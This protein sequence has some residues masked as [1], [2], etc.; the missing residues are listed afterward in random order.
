MI[1]DAS[2]RICMAIR[3]TPGPA[4]ELADP[5]RV[6]EER[7]AGLR[8]EPHFERPLPPFFAPVGTRDPLLDDTRRLEKALAALNV[9]VRG[10]VLPWRVFMRSTPS[11]GIRRHAGAGATRSR[12]STAT[13]ASRQP[14]RTA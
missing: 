14:R 2:R 11:S 9:P 3:A 12:F 6:L 7:V 13:C 8:A 4:T 10:T 5:L 1:R